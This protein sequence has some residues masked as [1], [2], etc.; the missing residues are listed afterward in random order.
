[1]LVDGVAYLVDTASPSAGAVI[2]HDQVW[3]VVGM[4]QPALL[5]LVRSI[6]IVA[7]GVEGITWRTP[8]LAV[9]DLRVERSSTAGFVC[10][11]DNLGG[12]LTIELDPT[13]GTQTAGTRLD[14]FWPPDALA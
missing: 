12:T 5:L 2:A 13:T 7:V 1:V 9:D 11:C 8:R 6:D 10:T 3:Q 4:D 14:S